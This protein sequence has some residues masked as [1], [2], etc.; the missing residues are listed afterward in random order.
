VRIIAARCANAALSLHWL[1]CKHQRYI[2]QV[3]AVD[4]ATA[5]AAA[6]AFMM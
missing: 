6:A 3:L 1:S 2:M 5:A 4:F